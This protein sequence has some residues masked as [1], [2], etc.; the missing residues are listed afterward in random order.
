MLRWAPPLLRERACLHADAPPTQT[1]VRDP[2]NNKALIAAGAEP[3]GSSTEEHAQ[4][5]RT[6][7]EKWKKVAKDAAIEPQ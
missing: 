4:S 7:I 5:I 6:E 2:E 1:A 3:L